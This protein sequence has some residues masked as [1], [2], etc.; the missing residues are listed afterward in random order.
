MQTNN[1]I[2]NQFIKNL[3]GLSENKSENKS[4]INIDFDQMQEIINVYFEFATGCKLYNKKSIINEID[5]D[6]LIISSGKSIKKNYVPQITFNEMFRSNLDFSLIFIKNEIIIFYKNTKVKLVNIPHI[7]N[8]L[9]DTKSEFFPIIP[10]MYIET[11]LMVLEKL[12]NND[13]SVQYY[14]INIPIPYWRLF[15]IKFNKLNS[16]NSIQ[17]EQSNCIQDIIT[18]RN[19]N[20]NEIKQQEEDCRIEILAYLNDE[21]IT[22]FLDSITNIDHK[23]YKKS[24]KENILDTL[25]Y[26]ITILINA[27]TNKIIRCYILYKILNYIIINKDYINIYK[28]KNSIE[29]MNDI[30]NPIATYFIYNSFE[31][32][33]QMT[34]ILNN[35]N[36]NI[37]NEYKSELYI[38]DENLNLIFEQINYFN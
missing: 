26:L 8:D 13:L 7:R 29:I 10:V 21:E 6:K 5:K 22:F 35:I 36:L 17:L 14:L 3:F 23:Y 38:D 27:P 24:N 12:I 4:E 34:I 33:K 19:Y 37:N 1:E 11:I 32:Y 9:F 15:E 25:N 2:F 16:K 31:F 30:Y 18:G 20:D 28:I